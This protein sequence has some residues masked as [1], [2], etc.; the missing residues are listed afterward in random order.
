MSCFAV[1][2]WEPLVQDRRSAHMVLVTCFALKILDQ[3]KEV[4]E[5]DCMVQHSFV[6]CYVEDRSFDLATWID[7][8]EV[9]LAC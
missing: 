4:W 9:Y 8:L 1:A 5:A 2:D 3:V 7:Q 6:A